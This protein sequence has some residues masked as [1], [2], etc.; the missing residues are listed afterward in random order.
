[1]CQNLL[2]A[3]E[4]CGGPQINWVGIFS[5][6]SEGL[7]RYTQITTKNVVISAPAIPDMIHSAEENIRGKVDTSQGHTVW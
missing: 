1:L 7:L 6:Y 5:L 4:R 2:T 3:I